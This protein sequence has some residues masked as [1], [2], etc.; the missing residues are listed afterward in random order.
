[1]PTASV[2]A[3]NQHL[4]PPNFLSLQVRVTSPLTHMVVG[5]FKGA[6]TTVLG[7][8]LYGNK[9]NITSSIGVAIL[10]T[11]SFAYSYLKYQHT[12][13]EIRLRTESSAN[14]DKDK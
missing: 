11:A 8:I 2:T 6:V 12:Q 4:F 9:M 5:A 3:K 1:M 10:I 13:S 7:V 14:T